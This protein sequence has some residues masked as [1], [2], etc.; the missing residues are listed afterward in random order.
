M[1]VDFNT[2]WDDSFDSCDVASTGNVVE[3]MSRATKALRKKTDGKVRGRFIKVKSLAESQV[4]LSELAKATSRF[5]YDD[6][7]ADANQLYASKRYAYDIISG[8][9]R[10]RLFSVVLEPVYPIDLIFDEGVSKEMEESSP[11]SQLGQSAS[12]V[13]SITSDD[14]LMV[15]FANAIS[16]RK[17]KYLLRRLCEEDTKPNK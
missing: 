17:V 10:F 6:D 2:L 8:T 9:Y 11:G 4:A 14:E 13:I 5:L 3:L 16:T 7:L 1:S 15:A 12:G